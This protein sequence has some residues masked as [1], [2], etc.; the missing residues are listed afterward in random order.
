MDQDGVPPERMEQGTVVDCAYCTRVRPGVGGGCP[1]CGGEGG[2]FRPARMMTPDLARAELLASLFLAEDPRRAVH[3][4]PAPARREAAEA[5]RRALVDRLE[6]VL[7]YRFDLEQAL[8]EAIRAL[9]EEAGL[10]EPAEET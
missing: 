1:L 5:A 7:L 6:D 10:A 2:G 9:E 8:V 4:A 3:D